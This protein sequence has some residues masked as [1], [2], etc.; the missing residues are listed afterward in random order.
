M[1]PVGGHRS[2]EDVIV[3]EDFT[4]AASSVVGNDVT[5]LGFP[6]C[7]AMDVFAG[8]SGP[9]IPETGQAS[10]GMSRVAGQ[11]RRRS[12]ER[13]E[14]IT[15]I[16]EP[17]VPIEPVDKSQTRDRLVATTASPRPGRGRAVDGG[18]WEPNSFLGS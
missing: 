18:M 8:Q 9:S 13:A 3:A 2:V 12:T 15:K 11:A 4:F 1:H 17:D 7:D 10:A 16:M 14:E 5:G 6:T